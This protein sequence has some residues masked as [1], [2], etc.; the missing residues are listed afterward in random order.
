MKPV[1][2]GDT[3]LEKLDTLRRGFDAPRTN[4]VVR[5]V[6]E[7]EDAI[8]ELKE[9]EKDRWDCETILS[10]PIFYCCVPKD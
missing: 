1:M 2:A 4:R 3:P 7:L 8:P 10:A 6:V 5:P 9:K